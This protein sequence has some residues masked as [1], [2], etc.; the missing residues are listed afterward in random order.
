VT[1]TCPVCKAEVIEAVTVAG[2]PLLLRPRPAPRGPVAAWSDGETWHARLLLS[3]RAPLVKD[4]RRFQ[5]HARDCG[6]TGGALDEVRKAQA[7]QAH[8][9]RSHRGR[10][11][12]RNP[13]A[14][15]T[16][17]RI[18]PPGGDR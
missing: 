11:A 10:P 1:G 2:T 16:G 14:R 6:G 18:P 17:V 13:F 15:I 8:K 7:A 12:T 9:A 3:A 5:P 4:E